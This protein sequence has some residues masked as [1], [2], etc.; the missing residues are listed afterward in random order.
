MHP[1]EIDLTL[2][3]I[4][5]LDLSRPRLTTKKVFKSFDPNTNWMR[6]NERMKVLSSAAEG[7]KKIKSVGMRMNEKMKVES[8]TE[9]GRGK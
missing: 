8:S 5:K 4:L 2:N 6:M 9:E 3:L 1:Q 7:R